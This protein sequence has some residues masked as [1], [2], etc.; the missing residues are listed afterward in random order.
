MIDAGLFVHATESDLTRFLAVYAAKPHPVV[1]LGSDVTA[2]ATASS[3]FA[4]TRSAHTASRTNGRTGR[5][6]S[7]LEVDGDGCRLPAPRSRRDQ[8]ADD[9]GNRRKGRVT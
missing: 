4:V 5:S 7:W 2:P 1:S 8:T 9:L 3:R 6:S